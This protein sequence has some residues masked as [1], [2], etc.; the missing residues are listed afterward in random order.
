MRKVKYEILL[1]SPDNGVI[2]INDMV[3]IKLISGQSKS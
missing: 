1:T 3:G 2:D